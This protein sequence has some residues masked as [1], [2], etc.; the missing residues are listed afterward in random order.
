M[1]ITLRETV[2]LV[3]PLLTADVSL[4]PH[5]GGSAESVLLYFTS[6]AME[7]RQCARTEATAVA[8]PLLLFRQIA[9]VCTTITAQYK[10]NKSVTR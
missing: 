9:F 5:S 3:S 2:H 10:C 7:M 8:Y 6:H 4:L 1:Q